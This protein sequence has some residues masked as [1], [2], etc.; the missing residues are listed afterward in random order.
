ML[1][2]EN[3]ALLD[4]FRRGERPALE[5]VYTAYADAVAGF[6]RSGFSFDSSGRACRFLGARSAFDLEDRVHDVFARAFSERARIAYDGLSPYR[7]YLLTIARNVVIDDFRRKENVLVEYSLDARPDREIQS[8][9]RPDLVHGGEPLHGE[10]AP[11]GLPQADAEAKEVLDLVKA[12]RT[13]IA[14]REQLIFKLRFEEEKDHTEIQK[15]TGLSP[16][17][18][19]TSEQ[20]IRERFFEFMHDRGYFQ[21]YRPA[22]R[23]WLS[24]MKRWAM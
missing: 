17:K 20:R 7:S 23:G 10:V 16:S 14:P 11:S 22:R 21:G 19:K 1:L 5:K 12:F 4:A 9:L 8:E 15:E 3:R 18:I 24:A 2:I 6:L 13:T